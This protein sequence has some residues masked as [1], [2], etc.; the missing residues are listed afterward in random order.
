VVY[1]GSIERVDFGEA[2]DKKYFVIAEVSRGK[3]TYAWR[4]IEGIRKFIDRAHKI[5]SDQ[6]VTEQ[7]RGALPDPEEM[8]DAI[9]RL[10]I[11]YPRDWESLIDDAALREMAAETFEFHLVKRPQMETRIRIPEDKNVGSL[12]P[13]QLLEIYW[14]SANTEAVDPARLQVLA[15]EIIQQVE[16]GEEE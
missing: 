14:K 7:L 4:E 2:K 5:E 8:R 15:R 6:Q 9:V 12:T 13:D 16:S 10:S 1:P 11:E 3:T